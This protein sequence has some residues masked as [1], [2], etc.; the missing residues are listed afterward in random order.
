MRN[1]NC[2]LHGDFGCLNL[3][4]ESPPDDDG[5]IILQRKPPCITLHRNLVLRHSSTKRKHM[6]LTRKVRLM[7]TTS[8]G[9]GGP[10]RY[11]SNSQAAT[12][13]SSSTAFRISKIPTAPLH[14]PALVQL[15][16]RSYTRT[17]ASSRGKRATHTITTLLNSAGAGA[18]IAVTPGSVD[19]PRSTSKRETECYYVRH[20]R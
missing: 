13:Q 8:S 17:M 12:L 2:T 11:R 10:A 15:F 16:S 4:K 3:C 5:G 18:S 19:G 6:Y 1:L 20:S 14:F 9:P 7:N